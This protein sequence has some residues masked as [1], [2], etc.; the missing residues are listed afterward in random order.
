MTNKKICSHPFYLHDRIATKVLQ[1]LCNL[2]ILDERHA[3]MIYPEIALIKIGYFDLKRIYPKSFPFYE[4]GMIEI[5]LCS[6]DSPVKYHA[7]GITVKNRELHSLKDMEL[8]S[9]LYNN[10]ASLVT[11]LMKFVSNEQTNIYEE[12]K[13]NVEKWTQT[14]AK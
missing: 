11:V 8:I 5:N 12:A 10:W 13:T 14:Y 6:Y 1:E 2:S 9:L 7:D 3:L 4:G